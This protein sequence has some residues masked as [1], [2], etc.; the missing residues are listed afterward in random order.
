MNILILGDVIGLSGREALINNLPKIIKEK[1]IDFTVVNGENSADDGRGITK[2]IAEIFFKSGVDVITSG[3]HI[4]DKKET[5]EFISKEK[6]LLRPANFAEGSPGN[7][8]GTFL[9][10]DKKFKVSVINLMGNVF[11][12]KTQDVFSAA[13]SLLKKIKL[14]ENSD[15]LIVD[16]HGE[17][18]SEKMAMGHFFDGNA[19]AVV[20]THTHVP[21]ADCRGLSKGTAYQTDIGMCGDYNSV[22]G[23]NK[24]N[25]LMK[26]LKYKD[27]KNHFPAEGE[28]TLSGIIVK[29]DI[30]TGLALNVE[31]IISGGV[32]KN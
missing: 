5:I 26:F 23:M 2:N 6:R 25:S 12:R 4:W 18:T 3:N 20:G 14:K 16:L 1:K 27:T 9:T 28:A 30:N 13:K 22:I 11:M 32:L 15:F 31:R 29:G 8:Y 7:G 24:E 21:T 19:T 17:I 10:K